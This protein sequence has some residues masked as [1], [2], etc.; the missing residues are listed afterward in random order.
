ML[1]WRAFIATAYPVI[2][3]QWLET[4]GYKESSIATYQGKIEGL[5]MLFQNYYAV[6]D[7]SSTGVT[8][9]ANELKMFQTIME[10]QLVLYRSEQKMQMTDNQKIQTLLTRLNTAA[11]KKGSQ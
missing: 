9:E 7:I 1:F 5:W 8:L 10:A 2:L 4:Q 11:Q 6:C 3:K